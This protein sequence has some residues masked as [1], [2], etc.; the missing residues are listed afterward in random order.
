ME[1]DTHHRILA[2]SAL[3]TGS[4]SIDWIQELTRNKAS[5]VLH[6]LEEAV[7]EGFV[8]RGDIGSFFFSDA[9]ARRQLQNSLAPKEREAYHRR[10]AQMFIQEL[11]NG[12]DKPEI[13]ASHLLNASRNTLDGCQWLMRAAKSH[14]SQYRTEAAQRCFIKIIEDLSGRPEPGADQLFC[15]AAIEFSKL[16]T[17]GNDVKRVLAILAEAMLRAKKIGDLGYQATIHMGFAKNKWLQSK[18]KSALAHFDSAWKLAQR[19][20]DPKLS[21]AIANFKTFL[22]YWQGLFKAAV[23][24]YE[25]THSD[26]EKFPHARFPLLAAMTVGTCY[27]QI[28]QVTQGIGMLDAIR[29]QCRE[30]GDVGLAAHSG[31]CIGATLIDIG[32]IDD[33]LRHLIP[34]VAEAGKLQPDWT[35]I[36]GELMLAYAYHLKE[37]PERCLRHLQRFYALSRQVDVSVRPW[38]YLM[39]LCWAMDEG[40]LPALP[41]ISIAREV[42]EAIGGGNI[43][44]KGVAFR[45]KALLEKRAAVPYPDIIATLKQSVRYLEL[46]GHAI[47]LAKTRL[48][49]ARLYLLQGHGNRA[50]AAAEAAGHIL[51]PLNEQLIPDDLKPLVEKSN[52]SDDSFTQLLDVHEVLSRKQNSKEAIQFMISTANR[53]AGAERGGI[54]LIADPR[55]NGRLLLRASKNLT[56]EQIDLP[57]FTS[58]LQMMAEVVEHRRGKIQGA[59]ARR[60]SAA[61]EEDKILSRICVPIV[62]NDQ[63][64]GVLYHDNRLLS[65]AFDASLLNRLS[66]LACPLALILQ[67]DSLLKENA[68]LAKQIT[69]IKGHYEQQP[70]DGAPAASGSIVGESPQIRKVL[71]QIGEI[72]PTDTTVLILGETG[73]GKELVAKAILNNSRRKDRPFISLNCSALSEELIYSELFG[74]EKGSFTGAARQHF[75]RFEKA[76]NGTL[77]LDEIGDLPLDI[78]VRLL[79]VLET[80][81]FERVGGKKTLRSDFRLI[82]A[83]NRNLEQAIERKLFRADLFYRIDVFPI[84]VPPLRE[85]KADIPLLVQS[86]LNENTARAG[87]LARFVSDEEMNALMAYDWPGNVRELKNCV[88]RF[89]ASPQTRIIDLLPNPLRPELQEHPAVSLQDNERRHI[90]WAL[91]KTHGKIHG[92]GGAAELLKIHPNTLTFRI[93]KLGISKQTYGRKAPKPPISG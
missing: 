33:A 79:R 42:Q 24:D 87:R 30:R 17:A 7:R 15:D 73:V 68:R 3:F 34:S 70:S 63:A 76:H 58:S 16:N 13:V 90:A 9:K 82:T 69:A 49:L 55:E 36:Q 39:A 66:A 21:R 40:R 65:N 6:S 92:P 93:K 72:A 51:Y 11:P 4:F 41:G 44:L 5:Q 78:Q 31:I 91:A 61:T 88:E 89:M 18:Y 35:T 54:F 50:R 1:N 22:L 84:H 52:L 45:F 57:E 74:H 83:T 77:F 29:G 46:S 38:P 28:G 25:R 53:I 37:Q 80:K 71:S 48:E 60:N 12:P 81:E 56:Q 47:E 62:L 20:G 59:G 64:M 27:G 23:G 32:R 86:F 75:G 67:N 10:I 26:V 2:V 43:F 85:R 19:I 8:Q 14:R